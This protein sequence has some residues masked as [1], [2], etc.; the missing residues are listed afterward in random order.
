MG[1]KIQRGKGLCSLRKIN[2]PA[3]KKTRH[4]LRCVSYGETRPWSHSEAHE[5]ILPNPEKFWPCNELVNRDCSSGAWPLPFH[6]V[7]L[8]EAQKTM[9]ILSSV[10]RRVTILTKRL[11][12]RGSCPMY[13]LKCVQLL[14]IL[15]FSSD[16]LIKW[17]RPVV[18]LKQNLFG[19][20]LIYLG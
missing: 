1:L 16:C 6:I 7:L 4:F 2:L 10:F 9:E 13:W 5:I 14:L 11:L 17:L 15:Y 19:I 12:W 3:H 18:F 20:H 8:F